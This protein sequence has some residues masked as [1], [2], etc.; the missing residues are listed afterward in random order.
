MNDSRPNGELLMA[1]GTL[2]DGATGNSSDFLEFPAELIPADRYFVMKSQI[3]ESMGF[4][5][6]ERFPCFADRMPNQLLAY[7]RLSRVSDPALFAKV[8][9]REVEARPA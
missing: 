6:K 2:P 8:G 4:G 3:L 9:R 5:P 1:T 7:I